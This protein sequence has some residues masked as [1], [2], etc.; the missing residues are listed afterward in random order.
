M[1]VVQRLCCQLC[2]E[3]DAGQPLAFEQLF[4]NVGAMQ[5]LHTNACQAS[6]LHVAEVVARQYQQLQACSARR[7]ALMQHGRRI[8]Q[9]LMQWLAEGSMHPQADLP[10]CCPQQEPGATFAG[11]L[12]AAEADA[13]WLWCL[14]QSEYENMVLVW[15]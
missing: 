7:L 4:F 3:A 14:A 9:S 1:Q 13:P 11:V 2:I 8:P 6:C 10:W 5:L 15:V 12:H